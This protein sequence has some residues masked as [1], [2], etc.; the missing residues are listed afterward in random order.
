MRS[1]IAAKS[2]LTISVYLPSYLKKR[3]VYGTY[4]QY[5]CKISLDRFYRIIHIANSAETSRSSAVKR[6]EA[7]RRAARGML[8]IG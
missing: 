5:T 2:I 4:N 6:C 7:S 1:P 3:I 8:M